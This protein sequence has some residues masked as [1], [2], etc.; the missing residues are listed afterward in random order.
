VPFEIPENPHTDCAAVA[1]FLDTWRR[2]GHGDYP[3]IDAFQFGQNCIFTHHGRAFFHY[4]SGAWIVDENGDKARDAAIE[5]GFMRPKADG[6][7]PDMPSG[8]SPPF[9]GV[10]SRDRASQVTAL[11]RRARVGAVLTINVSAIEPRDG[12]FIGRFDVTRELRALTL[13]ADSV[14]G[15]WNWI[16][17]AKLLVQWGAPGELW[18]EVD[19][20]GEVAC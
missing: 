16:S 12:V 19:L 14:I 2:N 7:L 5:T 10:W 11:G 20:P 15:Q 13:E 3:T 17:A 4:M 8:T 1:W 18:I 9:G 6:S